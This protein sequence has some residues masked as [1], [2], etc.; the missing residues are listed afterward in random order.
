MT[1]KDKDSKQA[2]LSMREKLDFENFEKKIIGLLNEQR[3]IVVATSAKDRVTARTVSFAND[4]LNI[5]FISW[6]HNLKIHQL[7]ENDHIALCLNNIQIEGKAKLVERPIED[8]NKKL[9]KIFRRKFSENYIKTFFNLPELI[10]VEIEPTR[11][12]CFENIH[13]RFFLQHMNFEKR[14]VYQMR[15]EDKEHPEFPY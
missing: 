6:D 10:T 4:G 11:I 13:N 1:S 5:Y 7:Q 12:V 15:I 14:T 8:K 9:E 3:H 2:I